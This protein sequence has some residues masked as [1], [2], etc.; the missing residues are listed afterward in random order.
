MQLNLEHKIVIFISFPRKPFGLTVYTFHFTTFFQSG[1]YTTIYLGI[2]SLS[3]A[4]SNRP[5]CTALSAC[6]IQ[7]NASTTVPFIRMSI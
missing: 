4:H 3:L 1:V 5:D 6:T 7:L 2:T